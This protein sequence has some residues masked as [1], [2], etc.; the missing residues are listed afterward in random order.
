MRACVC[1]CA[2]ATTQFPSRVGVCLCLCVCSWWRW[3]W[4]WQELRRNAEQLGQLRQRR[5]SSTLDRRLDR[6]G[7]QLQ[8]LRAAPSR[9]RA[10]EAAAAAAVAAVAPRP[11]APVAS[12]LCRGGNLR[13]PTPPSAEEAARAVANAQAQA[14]HLEPR[15]AA[16]VMTLVRALRT[17]NVL[18]H[19]HNA[20]RGGHTVRWSPA[21]GPLVV[22]SVVD[23]LRRRRAG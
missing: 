13:A 12:Q 11:G 10:A 9:D 20:V 16:A 21:C 18:V 1:L 2:C 7:A 23:T 19:L 22:G 4:R 14:Q 3:W 17:Q 6:L 15:A 5:V 8:D